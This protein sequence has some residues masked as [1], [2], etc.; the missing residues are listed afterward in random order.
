MNEDQLRAAIEQAVSENKVNV[1]NE[2]APILEQKINQML[3]VQIF[4]FLID[5]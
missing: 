2:L 3:I 5:F 1:V 4:Y